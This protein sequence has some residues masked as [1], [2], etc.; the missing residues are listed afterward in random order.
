MSVRSLAGEKAWDT[1]RK[2]ARKLSKRA[3]KA[4][5]TRLANWEKL[6]RS[7]LIVECIPEENIDC[8]EG[9]LLKEMFRIIDLQ[10]EVT[11]KQLIGRHQW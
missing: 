9:K 7:I 2:K 8:S 3:R 6:R 1:R 11:M 4:W 10:M 5:D